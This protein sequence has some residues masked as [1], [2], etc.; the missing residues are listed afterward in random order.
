MAA[1][2]KNVVGAGT[3]ALD[4]VTIASDQAAD[5]FVVNT[6][7]FTVAAASGNTAVAGTLTVT[8]AAAFNGGIACDTNKFTVADTSGNVAT[9]GTLACTGDFAVN[10]NKLTVTAASGN[11]ASAGSILSASATGGVGYATGAGGT[12]TQATN[13]TTG[14]TINKAVGEIVLASASNSATPAT[15]TVTNSA[16]AATDTIIVVQKSGTDP[17]GLAVTNVAAGSFKV[18]VWALSGTTTEAPKL[19]FAVLKGVAA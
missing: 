12:V 9:A 4:K 18:T 1:T 3:L 19:S 7:K 5:G 6:D 16:V 11:V 2:N 15:F 13:R 17:L 8:G 10:T 14:V